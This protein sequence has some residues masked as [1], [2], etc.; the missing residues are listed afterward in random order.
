[1]GENAGLELSQGRAGVDP[2]LVDQVVTGLA[3]SPQGFGLASGPVKGEHE[4]L[5]QPLAKRVFPAQRLQLADELAVMAQHQ[6]GFGAGLGRHQGQVVQV[7]PLGISEARI[8]ELTERLSPPQLEGFAAASMRPAP[9]PLLRAG[10]ALWPP[11]ARS[12]PHRGRPDR[13]QRA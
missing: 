1:M 6:V 10:A 8:R 9:S 3:V 13:R 4:Q 12:G 5:P 2:E 11:A 7:R